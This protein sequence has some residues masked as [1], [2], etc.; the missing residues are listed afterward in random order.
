MFS[1]PALVSTDAALLKDIRSR[2]QHG[3]R[4]EG[5]PVSRAAAAFII[6]LWIAAA[7]LLVWVFWPTKVQDSSVV[8]KRL[9]NACRHCWMLTPTCGAVSRT[10]AREHPLLLEVSK[11]MYNRWPAFARAVKDG[12]NQGDSRRSAA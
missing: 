7:F 10:T 4:R 9:W 6:A 1:G 2:R 12:G 3:S 5:R 8:L 11:A